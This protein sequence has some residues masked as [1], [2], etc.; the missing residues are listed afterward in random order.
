MVDAGFDLN[1]D[2][3]KYI[4]DNVVNVFDDIFYVLSISGYYK[5]II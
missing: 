4:Q 1:P 2:S 5:V 3:F